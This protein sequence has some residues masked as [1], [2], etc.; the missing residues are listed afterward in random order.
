MRTKLLLLGLCIVLLVGCGVDVPD[1]CI[2]GWQNETHWCNEY[3]SIEHKCI[4]DKDIECP[5]M[6][7][8]QEEE[9][10][11][12]QSEKELNISNPRL[13]LRFNERS[14]PPSE[15]IP[16]G[17][18]ETRVYETVCMCSRSVGISTQPCPQYCYNQSRTMWINGSLTH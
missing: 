6:Y 15:E 4:M 3:H 18:V 10:P 17:Y 11:E 2:M 1:I 12:N 7:P 13:I 8:T 16:N 5:D 9:K 14:L